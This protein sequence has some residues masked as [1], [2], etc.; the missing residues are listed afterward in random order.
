M[1]S[2]ILAALV[3]LALW[4]WIRRRRPG[5]FS[6]PPARPAAP[7]PR[8][9]PRLG[10]PGSI[11]EEQIDALQ[12]NRFTPSTQWSFDEAALVLDAVDYL[13]AVCDEAI[14][15][16]EPDLDIQN[17]L[18][19]FILGEEDLRNHVR[20][21]GA[22]RRSSGGDTPTSLPRNHQFERVAAKAR[23]LAPPEA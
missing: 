16:R 14:G 21:W 19:A 18:L 20:K 22:D 7:P 5:L 9:M 1:D 13:R 4:L 15:E 8:T 6:P 12:R 11:T 10:E 3:A 2:L 17:E 23:R